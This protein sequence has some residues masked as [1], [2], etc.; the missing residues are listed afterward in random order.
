MKPG[1]QLWVKLAVF[2]HEDDAMALQAFLLDHGFDSRVYDDHIL[3]TFLFLRPPRQTYRTQ[4]H[5]R[6]LDAAH[7]LISTEPTAARILKR[8]FDCPSCGSLSVQYPQMTRKFF[9]PTIFLHL[10]ILLRLIDHEAYCEDCHFIWHLPQDN[11]HA[12]PVVASHQAR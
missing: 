4:V 12:E 5:Q 9:T 1:N 10:G 7:E 11:H 2:P 6:D 3:R 8:A